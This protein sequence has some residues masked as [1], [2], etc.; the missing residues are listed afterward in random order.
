MKRAAVAVR[1][2]L[3]RIAGMVGI[4]GAFLLGGTA[5]LSVFASAIHP[6]GPWF[7]VGVMCIL[8]GIALAIPERRK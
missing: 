7:V 1:A 5:C 8:A 4:E 2:L 6:L 3:S